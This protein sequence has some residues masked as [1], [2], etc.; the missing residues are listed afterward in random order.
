[1]SVW[2]EKLKSQLLLELVKLCSNEL[3]AYFVQCLYQR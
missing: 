1:M 3:L 2:P